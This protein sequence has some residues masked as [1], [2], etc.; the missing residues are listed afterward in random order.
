[1]QATDGW[2]I[3]FSSGVAIFTHTWSEPDTGR[4]FEEKV[5]FT[6]NALPGYASALHG[7]VVD[8][9]AT[10]NDRAAFEAEL[11]SKGITDTK[12]AVSQRPPITTGALEWYGGTL[13]V[14]PESIV[15]HVTVYYKSQRGY[16]LRAFG[17]SGVPMVM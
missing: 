2:A 13:G 6:S 16:L 9:E 4:T 14:T 10:E 5:Y 15:A 11:R 1:M 7:L 8:T 17:F 3:Q 12:S